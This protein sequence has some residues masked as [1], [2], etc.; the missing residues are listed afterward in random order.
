MR[1]PY[2]LPKYL[3]SGGREA[4]ASVC[5]NLTPQNEEKMIPA[6][7]WTAMRLP[8]YRGFLRCPSGFSHVL[9]ASTP[10]SLPKYL[11]PCRT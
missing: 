11:K 4:C 10:P 8:K 5:L 6:R 1:K 2:C 7:L 9:E 3:S